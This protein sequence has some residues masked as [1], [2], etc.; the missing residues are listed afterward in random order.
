MADIRCL[1]SSRASPRTRP[2]RGC[3]HGTCAARAHLLSVTSSPP[4]P[5]PLLPPPP[6]PPAA[7]HSGLYISFF[8]NLKMVKTSLSGYIRTTSSSPSPPLPLTLPV[9]LV[10][11]AG[12]VWFAWLVLG[13]GFRQGERA[14]ILLERS[15]NS[16]EEFRPGSRA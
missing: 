5:S 15:R 14:R 13:S 10:L 8:L 4:R 16:V 7:H 9:E 11:V 2:H 12:F 6:P 1:F 3:L